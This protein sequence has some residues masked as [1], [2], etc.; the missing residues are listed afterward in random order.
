MSPAHHVRPSTFAESATNVMATAAE[1]SLSEE[2]GDPLSRQEKGNLSTVHMYY[3][4]TELFSNTAKITAIY[5][6]EGTDGNLLVL[7]T[8]Q[9]VMHPQGGND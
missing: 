8:D 5:R 7:V 6:A 4:D 2:G 3:D 9:T 1:P